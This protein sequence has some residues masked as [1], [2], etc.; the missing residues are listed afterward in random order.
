MFL[1]PFS[2][3]Y[4]IEPIL[5]GTLIFWLTKMRLIL[6]IWCVKSEFLS[7][8]CLF[9]RVESHCSF[10]L[11]FVAQIYFMEFGPKGKTIA[12]FSYWLCTCSVS[13][14]YWG[15]L[16]SL[17]RLTSFP[18]LRLCSC[19]LRLKVGT[20]LFSCMDKNIFFKAWSSN[21]LKSIQNVLLEL[22]TT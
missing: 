2:Y 8:S 15:S 13:L 7:V 21:Q 1:Q 16:Q 6:I 22:Y 9:Y 11:Y 20:F 17:L 4:N 10:Y 19:L 12:P 3:E 5:Q 14:S 18:C